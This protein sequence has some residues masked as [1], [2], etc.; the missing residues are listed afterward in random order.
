L[1]QKREAFVIAAASVVTISV[2]AEVLAAI[3]ATSP[4]GREADRRPDGRG[5]YLI[6]LPRGVLDRL[7]SLCGPGESYSDVILRIAAE[8]AQPVRP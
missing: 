2:S 4:D 6:R 7:R 8:T 5:G 1:L 3:E